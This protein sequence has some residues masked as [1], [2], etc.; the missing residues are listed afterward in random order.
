MDAK[1]VDSTFHHKITWI[2]ESQLSQI[3]S[4]IRVQG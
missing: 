2:E 4:P 3:W 1:G